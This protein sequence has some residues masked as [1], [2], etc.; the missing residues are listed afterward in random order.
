MVPGCSQIDPGGK[1]WG[2]GHG[3]EGVCDQGGPL[4]ELEAQLPGTT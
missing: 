3:K 4:W 1:G 2:K